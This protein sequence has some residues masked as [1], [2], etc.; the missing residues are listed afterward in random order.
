MRGIKFKGY[1]HREA[2]TLRDGFSE[3]VYG[4][5]FVDKDGLTWIKNGDKSYLVNPDSVGQ[6]T[7]KEDKNGN[8][9]YGEVGEL[10][11]DIVRMAKAEGKSQTRV[12]EWSQKGYWGAKTKLPTG[13]SITTIGLEYSCKYEVIG[14][15]F[16]DSHLLEGE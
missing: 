6:Y 11:G 15:M 14:N 12:I 10:G 13:I 1:C 8:K 5:L 9:I 16:Q 2:N 7:G 4:F 3:W